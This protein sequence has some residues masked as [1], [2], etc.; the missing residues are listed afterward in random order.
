MGMMV[1]FDNWSL[2]LDNFDEV[3]ARYENE[4]CAG[5]DT[6]V[7][8]S[9]SSM[10][11]SPIANHN[12]SSCSSAPSAD[13]SAANELGTVGELTH[14]KNIPSVATMRAQ[15]YESISSNMNILQTDNNAA[16][17]VCFI[18]ITKKNFHSLPC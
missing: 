8:H 7:T 14:I 18:F 1:A 11:H 10:H 5:Q 13:N 9:P 16:R 17:K 2:V 15:E 6:I 12:T 3:V 4:D